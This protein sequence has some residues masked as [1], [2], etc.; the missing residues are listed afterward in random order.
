MGSASRCLDARQVRPSGD[1]RPAWGSL[2]GLQYPIASP[3]DCHRG[4][5]LPRRRG[6]VA[7]V[8]DA[9]NLTSRLAGQFIEQRL[10]RLR[11]LDGGLL[12]LATMITQPTEL[13][14]VGLGRGES[15]F[16]AL[17]DHAT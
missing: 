11:P 1:A 14:A 5:R 17:T 13:F 12:Q 8:Q 6:H 4:P 15:I 16:G 10:Q 9:S 3:N 2:R 7:L